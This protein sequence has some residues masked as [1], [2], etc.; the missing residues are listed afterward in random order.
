VQ[1]PGNWQPVGIYNQEHSIMTAGFLDEQHVATGGVNGRMG[2]SHDGAKT[3]LETSSAADCRYGIDIV[4]PQIIWT[5]GGATNVRRSMDG[6]KTWKILAAFGNPRT[7]TNPCHSMSFLDANTGWLANSNLFGTTTDGG[8]SWQMQALPKTANQIATIDTYA[9]GHGYLLDQNGALFFTQD[10][11]L[12]WRPAGQL[13]LNTLKMADS[14]YQLAAMRFSD[15]EHGL[16]V[17]SS[18]DSGKPKPIIAFQTQN[19]GLSWVSKAV[20]VMAG[21]V[22]LSRSGDFL[23]IISAVNQLTLL[24]Y[25]PGVSQ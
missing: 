12:H 6:G 21:P 25:E 13:P 23:T 24:R 11:G 3:W 1:L 15:A 16:I 8:A 5:C 17:V 19:G 18:S 2:S 22:Y 4:S 9:P 7:I 20:P 10:N 14:V